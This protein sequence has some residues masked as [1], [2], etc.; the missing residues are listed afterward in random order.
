MAELQAILTQA[1][2]LFFELIQWLILIRIFLSWIPIPLGGISQF[3]YQTTE[4]ILGPARELLRKSPLGGG[5]MLDFSPIIAL[6][7]MML[8]KQLL[9]GLVLLF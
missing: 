8:V 4:P 5:M 1:I 6:I 7:L 9:T 3:I 2:H